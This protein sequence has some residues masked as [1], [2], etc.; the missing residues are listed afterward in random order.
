MAEHAHHASHDDIKVPFTEAEWDARYNTAAH[1]MWSGNPNP[2]LVD[3]TATLTPGTALDVGCGEGADALWLASRGWKVTG[4]DISSVALE[5][6]AAQGESQGLHVDW[7][8]VDLLEEALPP[9]PYDLVAAHFMHLPS[10]LRRKLYARLAEAVADRGTLLLVGHHP[11]DVHTSAARPD[12]P[13]MFF[14]AEELAADLDPATWKILVTDARP[15]QAK[16]PQGREITIRD[17]VLVARKIAAA[18]R[19]S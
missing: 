1:R 7:Q 10:A 2:V 17:T 18:D 12:L 5:R 11:S 14:T 4:I 8:R 9:G 6:A 15:R 13:D 16:D 3:E 19:R